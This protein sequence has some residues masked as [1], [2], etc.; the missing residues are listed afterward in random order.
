VV[1]WAEVV[2]VEEEVEAVAARPLGAESGWAAAWA[3]EL[4]VEKAEAVAARLLSAAAA[5][6]TRI[7]PEERW[8]GPSG[9]ETPWLA[10]SAKR[11]PLPAGSA[12]TVE[13][14]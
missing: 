11:F 14:S 5:V 13:G 3:E 9:A 2:V 7:A 4:V 8:A 12:R 1:A 6:G 10:D